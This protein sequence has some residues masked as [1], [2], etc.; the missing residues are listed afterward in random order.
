MAEEPKA[1][2][3]AEL[4][5]EVVALKGQLAE[6]VPLKAQIEGQSKVIGSLQGL[7][8]KLEGFEETLKNLTPAG[9]Q[10]RKPEGEGGGDKT[11][12]QQVADMRKKMED[13][14]NA[15]K[16]EKADMER[17]AKNDRVQREIAD[18][19]DGKVFNRTV[20]NDIAERLVEKKLKNIPLEIDDKKILVDDGAKQMPLETW[21]DLWLNG[22]GADYQVGKANP[23][24]E[25][26]TLGGGKL[27]ATSKSLTRDR[28]GVVVVPALKT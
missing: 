8:K 7:P 5:A 4:Q 15:H 28:N 21:L 24:R 16:T 23:S 2:T 18:L 25:G 26:L 10:Q 11:L 3:T 19:L 20:A 14:E 9:L 27:S 6:F 12:A 17:K 1:L 22:E 13:Q